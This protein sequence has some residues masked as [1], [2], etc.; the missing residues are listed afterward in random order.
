M[1]VAVVAKEIADMYEAPLK[2]VTKDVS[3]FAE[4]LRKKGLI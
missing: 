2:Q 3:A 1:D 4:L